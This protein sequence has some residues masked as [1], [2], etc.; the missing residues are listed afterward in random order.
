MSY[1]VYIMTNRRDGTLY[2]GVTNDLAP[3]VYEHREKLMPGFT[4]KYNL[5]RLVYYEGYASAELAI[6]REKNMKE[7][8]RAWKIE[9]VEKMNPEWRDLYEDLS[10]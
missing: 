5:D 6:R 3:R 9:L 8:K 10:K 7:W 4:Q 2:N 1:F